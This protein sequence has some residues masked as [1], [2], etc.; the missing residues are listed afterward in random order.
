[1]ELASFA[2][3]CLI[4]IMSFGISFYAMQSFNFEKL[5]KPGHTRE[6]QV[7]YWLIVIALAYLA[8]QFV[9]SFLYAVK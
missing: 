7:L 9:I 3:R 5:L 8:G 2:I 4:Y 6:A 1:M